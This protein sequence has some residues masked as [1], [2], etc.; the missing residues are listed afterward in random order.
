MR[1][2][3]TEDEGLRFLSRMREEGKKLPVIFTVGRYEPGRGTP[4]YAFG[5]TS[6]VDELLNL[7]FDSLSEH[8]DEVKSCDAH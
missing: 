2:G 4:P 7:I 6:R 8:V 3:T 1:R 5:R